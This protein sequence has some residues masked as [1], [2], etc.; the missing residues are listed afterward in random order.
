MKYYKKNILAGLLTSMALCAPAM[1]QGL[2]DVVF[3]SDTTGSMGDLI[4]SAKSSSNG[5]Y[6]SF[7]ARGDVM[8]GVGEYRDGNSDAF[9]HRFNL[10]DMGAAALSSDGARVSSAIEQWTASGGG[11]FPEDNLLALR[12]T[13][14]DTPWR[15]GSKRIVFWFGDAPGHDP[16][17]DGTTMA[18]TLAALNAHC[19]QV[20]AIDLNDLDGTGQATIITDNTLSCGDDGGLIEDLST[21]TGA[22]LDSNLE[23]I[24][25]N[26]FN[27]VTTGGT[28]VAFVSGSRS[29]SLI[30]VR[31]MSRDVSNRLRHIRA[32]SGS[33]PDEHAAILLGANGGAGSGAKGGISPQIVLHRP[34]W[35]AW[36]QVY[37]FTENQDNQVGPG[38]I[39]IH[40][41]L[42]ID[43]YGGSVGV[44]RQLN[45]NWAIGIALGAAKTDM[46][47]RTVGDIDMDSISIS[48]YA[49]YSRNNAWRGASVYADLFYAY[50]SHDYDTRR[51]G[52]AVGST[53][54]ESHQI[55]LNTGLIFQ[56]NSINHGPYTEIR[57]T[58]GD[59]DAYTET[60]P[61]ALAVASTSY[62]SFTTQL[63]Y[64]VSRDYSVKLGKLTPSARIGWEH[65]FKPDQGS[66]GAIDLGERDEDVGVLGVGMR[67]QSSNNWF[68]STDYE[69]RKGS[70][71]ESHYIGLNLSKEF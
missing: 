46:D 12:T 20:V 10:N 42:E 37:A 67:L 21:L 13:A 29:G 38:S 22:E 65:E 8:F 68:L 2:F 32:I 55:E 6:T 54:G 43:V 48:P 39:L 51:T 44:D 52:G 57:Y 33:V 61:G 17:S 45:R 59:I 34:T 3:L 30:T 16:A 71:T 69:F 40:P 63:G 25:L 35:E 36:G 24:L 41:D 47:M 58:T 28:P 64:Q 70:D 5:I 23:S 7:S 19:V 14:S 11:D 18:T 1:S 60:G 62:D 4:S 27:E 53:D 9:A 49:S 31:T 56:R 50:G 15:V 66:I 26:L